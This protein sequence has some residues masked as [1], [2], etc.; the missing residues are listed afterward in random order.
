MKKITIILCGLL[1]F[2]TVGFAYEHGYEHGH[3]HD[4][5]PNKSN[6]TAYFEFRDSH[7]DKFIVKLTKP[8]QIIRARTI[9]K[10]Y[11]NFSTTTCNE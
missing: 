4:Y 9:L 10:C 8:A 3:E 6:H 11:K 2:S 5:E 7:N 1:G